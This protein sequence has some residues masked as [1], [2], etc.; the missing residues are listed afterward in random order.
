MSILNIKIYGE[1]VLRE[2]ARPVKE[3]N[4]KIIDLVRDM[5][6]TMYKAPGAGLAANQV[7]VLK[8]IIVIDVTGGENGGKNL[9]ALINP[10]I[11]EK[12]GLMEGDEGCLS[13]PGITASVKRFAKVTICGLNVKGKPVKITASDLLSKAL[14]HEIDHLNGVLFVDH[15]SFTQK[16]FIQNKLKELEKHGK[17]KV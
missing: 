7:G 8:R 14:Q 5:A 15:L 12:D 9:I 11:V 4:K 1:E 3:I 10:E 17:A 16:I 2:K 13:L 6:D